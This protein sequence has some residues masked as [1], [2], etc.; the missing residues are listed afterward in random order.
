[1]RIPAIVRI[2]LHERIERR[3]DPIIEPIS[4]CVSAPGTKREIVV[5]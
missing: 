1:M 4:G 5:V 2:D 3:T